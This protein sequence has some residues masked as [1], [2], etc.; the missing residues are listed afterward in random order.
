MG[1]RHSAIARH[2]STL[3]H[4]DP[5][6]DLAEIRVAYARFLEHL[7]HLSAFECS[8]R[9]P[10]SLIVHLL[11]V[12]GWNQR[13]IARDYRCAEQEIRRRRDRIQRIWHQLNDNPQPALER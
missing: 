11:T 4:R 13:Q 2:A 9:V 7:I 10:P 1:T 3:E 8:S 6:A 12:A 5:T